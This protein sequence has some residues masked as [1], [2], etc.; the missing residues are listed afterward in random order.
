MAQGRAGRPPLAAKREQFARLIARGVGSAEAC[1]IVGV[2]PK[3]GKRWRRGR[4]VTSG[5][6]ARLH[7]APVV[8]TRR[9]LISERYLS[10]DD[11]VV[12]ADLRGSGLGVRA[13]AARL[14]RS[15]STVSRELRRNR[16]I[17]S[18][19][20]RPFAAQVM[21]ARRRARPGRGKLLRDSVLREFVAGRLAARWSP[22]QVS[23]ALR[24]E[25]PG[26]AGRHLQRPRNAWEQR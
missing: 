6:G 11:R 9:Q 8:G 25:F 7:Y 15:P 1:R 13:I 17:G 23:H 21:A 12:I 22:E 2:H 18:G 3:T 10:E 24:G 26:D 16:D 5:S 19:Q 4:V 20:Y 14:G